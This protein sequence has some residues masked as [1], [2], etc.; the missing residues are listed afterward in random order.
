MELNTNS[1][2]ITEEWLEENL[3][4]SRY[5]EDTEEQLNYYIN[6]YKCRIDNRQ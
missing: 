5:N 6:E 3:A 4:E 2:I 1:Q